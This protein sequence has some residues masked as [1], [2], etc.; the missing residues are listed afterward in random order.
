MLLIAVVVAVV[1]CTTVSYFYVFVFCVISA[2]GGNYDKLR[3][4][5]ERARARERESC[6]YAACC[7]PPLPLPPSPSLS[8]VTR[9]YERLCNPCCGLLVAL[10]EVKGFG[11]ARL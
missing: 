9:A 11:Q 6:T 7:T 2:A 1:G 3:Q 5:F 4:L 10:G 8:P